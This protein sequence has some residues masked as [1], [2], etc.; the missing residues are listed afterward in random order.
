MAA[1]AK[2]VVVMAFDFDE[3]GNLQPAFEPREMPDEDRAKR[4]A[5]ELAPRHAGVI[6]WSRP[7]NPTLGEFGE[8]E[9][10]FTAGEVP[11]ME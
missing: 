9:I 10:L 7:A 11:D 4:L 6:A 2:L 3:E 8:P 5:R 1:P